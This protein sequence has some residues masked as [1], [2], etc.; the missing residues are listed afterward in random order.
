M[1][2]RLQASDY[3]V[4]W[5]CVLPIGLPAAQEMLDE[6]DADASRYNSNSNLYT[7]GRLS[8]RKFFLACL[9]RAG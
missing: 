2:S 9:L 1:I 5:I 7:L 8:D 6:E 4:G 3:T